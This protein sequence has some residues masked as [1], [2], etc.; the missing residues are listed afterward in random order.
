MGAKTSAI[1][2]PILIGEK[3]REIPSLGERVSQEVMP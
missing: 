2:V 3:K 1:A